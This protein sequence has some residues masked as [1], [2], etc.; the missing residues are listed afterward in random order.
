MPFVSDFSS[1]VWAVFSHWVAL[2]TG[3]VITALLLVWERRRQKNIPTKVYW[4]I[5]AFFVLLSF[6]LAWRD[7]LNQKRALSARIDS[8]QRD[9]D[10]SKKSIDKLDAL[11]AAQT[12]VQVSAIQVTLDTIQPFRESQQ[13]GI[14]VTYSNTGAY[15]VLNF[16]PHQVVR[17]VNSDDDIER[18]FQDIYG[19]TEKFIQSG[20]VGSVLDP[21][22]SQPR[23]V[24]TVVNPTAEDVHAFYDDKN[25]L[26]VGVRVEYNDTFWYERCAFLI[27]ANLHGKGDLWRDCGTHNNA[28]QHPLGRLF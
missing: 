26:V 24:S 25:V 13:I 19:E 11:A 28:G 4:L 15:R 23:M 27:R 16:H 10:T 5:I 22:P 9:I 20:R 2:V 1:F 14:N 7:Q 6:F 21:G 12:I 18:V 17:F 3:G 8:L